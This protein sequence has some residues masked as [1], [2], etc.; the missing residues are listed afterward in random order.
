MVLDILVSHSLSQI[1]DQL[2]VRVDD[3]FESFDRRLEAI[4]LALDV[5]P[6]ALLDLADAFG[7]LGP[8]RQFL[9]C[10]VPDYNILLQLPYPIREVLISRLCISSQTGLQ[11]HFFPELFQSLFILGLRKSRICLDKL[12]CLVVL[13]NGCKPCNFFL[14]SLLLIF[15]VLYVQGHL[16]VKY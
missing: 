7:H 12:G 8:L 16:K 9:Q 4:K 2:R 15:H 3:A 13:V 1:F 6:D 10:S 14:I 5:V 11:L